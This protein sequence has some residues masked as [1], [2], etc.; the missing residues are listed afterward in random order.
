M[1]AFRFAFLFK[2]N[3]FAHMIDAD[4]MEVFADSSRVLLSCRRGVLK[5]KL[6]LTGVFSARYAELNQDTDMD[7][8]AKWTKSG[9]EGFP[10]RSDSGVGSL[11]GLSP[12]AAALA[13]MILLGLVI[14]GA[15][16]TGIPCRCASGRRPGTLS[17]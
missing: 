3:S 16:F 1:P 14:A 10:C 5:F 4:I 2:G 15:C 17:A 13:V 6:G 9:G 8:T 7:F 12:Q 11:F